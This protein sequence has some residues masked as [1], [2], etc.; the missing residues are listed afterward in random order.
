MVNVNKLLNIEES[1][2]E[3]I[4][5]KQIKEINY[6]EK[7][8]NLSNC[9]K[10]F[11][12][13]LDI[14]IKRKIE[15]NQIETENNIGISIFYDKNLFRK[16]VKKFAYQS[17][18]SSLDKLISEN[19]FMNILKEAMTNLENYGKTDIRLLFY[20]NKN[21]I[22]FS[23][24]NNTIFINY[25]NDKADILLFNRLNDTLTNLEL[26]IAKERDSLEQELKNNIDLDNESSIIIDTNVDIPT[27]E[28]EEK[29][30]LSFLKTLDGVDDLLEKYKK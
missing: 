14:A 17:T 13:I 20:S 9:L 12:E 2:K 15:F 25:E 29:E 26:D 28:K 7:V 1:E 19:D 21:Y 30:E 8:Y 3:I 4:E 23:K 16:K 11:I 18:M 27:K 24:N 10:G 6:Q 5:P 22:G